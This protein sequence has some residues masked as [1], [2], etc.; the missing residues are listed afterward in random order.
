MRYSLSALFVALMPLAA[1]GFLRVA[2]ENKSDANLINNS[3]IFD[4]ATAQL[5]Q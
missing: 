2:S 5:Q 4:K 3:T 1:L